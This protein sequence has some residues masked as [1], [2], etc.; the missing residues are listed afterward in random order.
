MDN[1]WGQVWR[2]ETYPNGLVPWSGA[3]AAL[4]VRLGG[5]QLLRQ[6]AAQDYAGDLCTG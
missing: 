6:S 4:A 1:D 2:Q 3:S 5:A